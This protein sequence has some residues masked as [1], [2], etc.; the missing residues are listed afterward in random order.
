MEST[1]RIHYLLIAWAGHLSN[2]TVKEKHLNL[3]EV[4]DMILSTYKNAVQTFF[5]HNNP[6]FPHIDRPYGLVPESLLHMKGDVISG[7]SLWRKFGELKSYVLNTINPI[8]IRCTTLR[9]GEESVGERENG[10]FLTGRL[11]DEVYLNIRQHLWVVKEELAVKKRPKREIQPFNHDWYPKEW[12]VF[13][14]CGFPAG[15]DALSTFTG[16]PQTAPNLLPIPRRSLIDFQLALSSSLGMNVNSSNEDTY[17][18][19]ADDTAP[20]MNLEDFCSSPDVSAESGSSQNNADSDVNEAMNGAEAAGTSDAMN[21]KAKSDRDPASM[22]LSEQI[23]RAMLDGGMDNGNPIDQDQTNFSLGTPSIRKNSSV[24]PL[25]IRVSPDPQILLHLREHQIQHHQAAKR[26]VSSQVNSKSSSSSSSSPSSRSQQLHLSIT[27]PAVNFFTDG[28]NNKSTKASSNALHPSSVPHTPA[29]SNHG[30]HPPAAYFRSLVHFPSSEDQQALL[31]AAGNRGNSAH[32]NITGHLNIGV[33]GGESHESQLN[34]A[35]NVH[36]NTHHASLDNAFGPTMTTMLPTQINAHSLSVVHRAPASLSSASANSTATSIVGEELTC[37]RKML[38]EN[39]ALLRYDL[40]WKRLD[41]L[42]QR[43]IAL[44]KPNKE[45][46]HWQQLLDEHI[47]NPIP[48]GTIAAAAVLGANAANIA[49]PIP[50]A[51]GVK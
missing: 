22:D 17:Q 31:L 14:Y 43:A 27:D 39:N 19:N 10:V 47:S 29:V 37:L 30:L 6:L 36:S 1:L 20:G 40:E 35:N 50:A 42:L 45:I 51:A 23:H 34:A 24:S 8:W 26:Q 44:Q 32:S 49:M 3:I 38:A 15:V 33:G 7:V 28:H 9:N 16:T 25:S 46:Q 12:F 48:V 5:D 18:L 2:L 21:V 13:V 4:Q 41:K 11:M